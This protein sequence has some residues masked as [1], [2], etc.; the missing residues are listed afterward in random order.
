MKL[1]LQAT[2]AKSSSVS[3]SESTRWQKEPFSYFLGYINI[4]LSI[5]AW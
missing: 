1:L 4:E 5:E 2:A 3:L